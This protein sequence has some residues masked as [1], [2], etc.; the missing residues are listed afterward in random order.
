MIPSNRE[1][2]KSPKV[3]RNYGPLDDYCKNIGNI[4]ILSKDQERVFSKR[5]IKGTN[6]YIINFEGALGITRESKRVKIKYDS[7]VSKHVTPFFKRIFKQKRL[8]KI[9]DKYKINKKGVSIGL[10]EGATMDFDINNHLNTSSKNLF[11]RY[12]TEDASLARQEMITSNLPFVMAFAQNRTRK[13][14]DT[15]DL[16]DLV[17]VGNL[18]LIRA[19]DKYDPDKGV[20]FANYA[21]NWIQQ[22][23][24]S[25]LHEI[26]GVTSIRTTS[27]LTMR[28]IQKFEEKLIAKTRIIPEDKELFEY[29]KNSRETGEFPA[30]LGR[31]KMKHIKFMRP[32]YNANIFQVD[33]FADSSNFYGENPA[34][35]YSSEKKPL[36]TVISEEE[37]RELMFQLDNLDERSQRVLFETYGLNGFEKKSSLEIG[38]ELG[39]TRGRVNQMK[40]QILAELPAKLT[41]TRTHNRLH[42]RK[43]IGEERVVLVG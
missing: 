33:E 36:D 2:H 13:L 19:I 12:R 30:H 9:L 35:F 23:I 14:R 4:S 15:G 6:E 5:I 31:I 38:E 29:I 28:T 34:A 26:T 7:A 10:K 32:L 21:A 18:G 8:D 42:P 25:Y 27:L 11:M 17:E 43:E 41:R 24:N 20:P 22:G 37:R 16:E 3:I 39:L 40:A 1:I